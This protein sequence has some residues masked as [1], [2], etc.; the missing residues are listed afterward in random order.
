MG[1]KGVGKENGGRVEMG[2]DD[3]G[4]MSVVGT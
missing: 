2:G 1:E 4:G 3:H